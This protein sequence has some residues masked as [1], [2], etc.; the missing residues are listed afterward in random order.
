[1][2]CYKEANYKTITYRKQGF[3]LNRMKICGFSFHI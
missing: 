2:Y 3:D 1:M